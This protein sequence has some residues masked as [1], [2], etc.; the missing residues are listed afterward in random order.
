MLFLKIFDDRES[1]EASSSTTA[2][3]RP[4]PKL[5]LA[6]P[7]PKNA[8][9]ITGDAAARLRQ[10]RPV[11]DAKRAAATR[12]NAAVAGSSAVVFEDANNYMKSGTLLRQV[13]NKINEDIDFNNADDRHSSATSTRRSSRTSRTPAT[14]A[15]TTP[16]APSP[17]SSWTRSIPKLGET[18]LDPACGTGGFLTCA[19]EHIRKQYVKTAKDEAT[20]QREHPRRREEAAAAPPLRDQHD[21]PRH[22]RAVQHPPRQHLAR[23]LRDY[24]PQGPGGCDR[25]QPAV[26]RHG[27][28]R[29]REQLPR[30]FRTT[31]DRGPLPRAHHARS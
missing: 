26:R 19:I 5:S 24:G 8:E 10:Q 15:N 21:L 20:L 11:P 27:R 3:S 23:P 2:T 18:I 1:R 7:G 29:H 13:I 22:R 6:R 28:G 17:S 14:P 4:S 31:R 16:P 12:K 25:H 30:Q 9:G